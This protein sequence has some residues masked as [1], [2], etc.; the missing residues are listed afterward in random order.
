MAFGKNKTGLGLITW[1]DLQALSYMKKK[2]ETRIYITGL[3]LGVGVGE[4][5]GGETVYDLI[6]IFFLIKS[7]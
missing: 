7:L 4:E 3:H 5:G 6:L 1:Q 2:Q